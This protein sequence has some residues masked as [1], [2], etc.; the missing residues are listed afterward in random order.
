MCKTFFS[1]DRPRA[2][3]LRLAAPARAYI[4]SVAHSQPPY[5]PGVTHHS[6]CF[7]SA[8][9]PPACVRRSVS[10]LPSPPLHT[11]AS[12][13]PDSE[14]ARLPSRQLAESLPLIRTTLTP[15]HRSAHPVQQP[16]LSFRAFD[17]SARSSRIVFRDMPSLSCPHGLPYWSLSP[18]HRPSR[19]IFLGAVAAAS[20]SRFIFLGTVAVA[21]PSRIISKG[22]SPQDL[23]PK[24]GFHRARLFSLTKCARITTAAT[25]AC[26]R[27]R[28]GSIR[29]GAVATRRARRASLLRPGA[30]GARTRG[31]AP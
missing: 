19:I 15:S 20:P 26:G 2:S 22:V 7:G 30:S 8:T 14:V 29:G 23:L 9:Q 27:R 24:L 12:S 11:S 13:T 18:L 21:S 25:R 17:R 4:S 1:S 6:P 28:G 3:G 5:S 16:I 31:R 10:S